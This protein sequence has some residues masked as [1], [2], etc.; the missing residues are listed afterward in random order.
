MRQESRQ[1]GQAVMAVMMGVMI[2]GGLVLWMTTGR[3][4][5]MPMGGG[6]MEHG[7]TNTGAASGAPADPDESEIVHGAHGNGENGSA[8]DA[9][10]RRGDDRKSPAPGGMPGW[11][12]DIDAP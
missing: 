6:H 1:K 4:H 2:I 11:R 9:A 8:P 7:K 3:F 12:M 5:M 10:E